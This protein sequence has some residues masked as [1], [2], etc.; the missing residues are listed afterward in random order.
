MAGLIS[1][2]SP[3]EHG[4]LCAAAALFTCLLFVAGCKGGGSGGGSGAEGNEGG[5]GG[6]RLTLA[7]TDA[8]VDSA[9]H[10]FVEFTAVTVKPTDGDAVRFAFDDPISVDLLA[11]R[12]GKSVILLDE[13]WIGVG[14][15]EWVRLGLNLDGELDTYLV[16]IDGGVHELRVPSGAQ[17]GLK[18]VRAFTVTASEP[19]ELL[20]DFDLRQSVVEAPPGRFMLKPVVRVVEASVRDPGDDDGEPEEPPEDEPGRIDAIATGTYVSSHQCGDAPGLQAVY[21]YQGSGV[22]PDDVDTTDDS[23][24]DPLKVL[25]LTDEDGDGTYS[26]SA[27]FLPAATYTVSYV[28]DPER[29]DPEGDDA[30]TYADTVDV[31]VPPGSVGLYEPSSP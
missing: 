20:L 5:D 19:T 8:P 31:V 12:D 23:N 3:R 30:L 6:G 29:D 9:L 4:R 10:V 21:I 24:I 15:F 26:G 11:Q 2:P 13:Q 18:V 14:D 1:F 22:T 25:V 16:A 28:C 27:A 17:T 7:V